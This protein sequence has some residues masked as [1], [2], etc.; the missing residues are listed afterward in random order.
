VPSRKSSKVNRPLISDRGVDII[1]VGASAGGLEA[2]Q[3]LLSNLPTIENCCVI[4]AQ[5]LSPTHKSMLVQ[6]LSK[7][8]KILV[9]E[10]VN[11]SQ[12][13]AGN[14]YI[15]PP[16]KEISVINGVIKL[17]KPSAPLGP[18]PSVDVL[19]SSLANETD[20]RV[21]GVIL[22]GTG[23]DGSHGVQALKKVGHYIIAQEPETAK[24][25]GMPLAA[26]ETGV[27][28]AVLSPE[29]IGEEIQDFFNDTVRA[30]LSDDTSDKSALSKILMLLGKRT[31]TDFSK[32]K[33]ATIGRRLLK[34]MSMLKIDSLDDYLGYLEHHPHEVDEMFNMILIG[35]T[36]F[37]RDFESFAALEDQ[38][39]KI[40]STKSAKDS[41]RIWVPGCSTG[42]EAYSVAIMLHRILED[43]FN[44]FNIQIF[45]TDIDE[46]AIKKGRLGI[47]PKTSID[48]VPPEIL[49]RYFMNLGDNYEL[50][51]PI[52]SVVLFSKHDVTKNPPFLNLDLISCRNLLIYFESSLQEQIIPIFHYALVPDGLL[53]LGKSESVG[54]FGD[55][56][57]NI[58]SK[59]KLFRRKL[60]KSTRTLKFSAFKAAHKTTAV[61][62]RQLQQKTTTLFDVL[63]DT[64]F[65]TYEHP[66]V[67]VD[68]NGDIKEVNG[69]VRLFMSLSTGTIHMNLIRMLNPELQIEVRSILSKAIKDKTSI[70]SGVK[71]FE[72]FG[73]QYFVRINVKSLQS[74]L[75]LDDLYLVIF[76]NLDISEFLL[77]GNTENPEEASSERLVE[78]EQELAATKEQLQTY[79][80]EI[81]TSNEEL[82]SLNEELQSTNEELQS[83]NEE[84]ETSNEELQ[85][86]NEEVQIAYTGLKAALDE[87]ELKEHLLRDTAASTESLLDND[88]QAFVLL[89][90]SYNVVRY[91]AKAD[92]TFHQL[93]NKKITTSKS[94]VDY[95]PSGNAE[96]FLNG[97]RNAL[98]G[99][100]LRLE[101]ELSDA[102]GNMR[103]YAMNFAPAKVSKG[104]VTGVSIGILDITDLRLALMQLNAKE[105][106]VR[107]VFDTV[108]TGICIVDELGNFVDMNDEFCRI[109]GYSKDELYN[110]TIAESPLHLV[111]H[112]GAF[113]HTDGHHE[114]KIPLDEHEIVR[115][116]GSKIVVSIA[117]NELEPLEGKKFTVL[118]VSDITLR[119]QHQESLKML[120]Q[121]LDHQA[122]SLA[123]INAEL[124]QFAYSASH[125]LQEPLRMIISFLTLLEKKYT[126]S[127]DAK[128]NEYIHYAVDGARRMRKIILDL[129]DYSRAGKSTDNVT[130]VDLNEVV[131]DVLRL[132]KQTIQE[133]KAKFDV[134]GLPILQTHLAPM[135]QLLS[136]LI[137]NSLKYSSDERSPHI[138]IGANLL[139]RHWEIYVKDNGIGISH[140]YFE[141]IFMVFQ[142][143]HSSE[144]YQGIGMGLAIVK[145]IVDSLGGTVRVESEVDLGS[146]FYFTLP[147]S[148][149]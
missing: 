70:R 117:H 110:G 27:V 24:Y 76:E 5:H 139:D 9:T 95:L 85:S 118:S 87:L 71:R 133:K 38:L 37:F 126:N 56:F 119:H 98:V 143:L 84:L 115:Q 10:A 86:T 2:L 120:N 148:A 44:D 60:T 6:L 1:A 112:D 104:P 19:F 128:A 99:V 15:T 94:I 54:Q 141:K 101:K 145:K 81:E 121:Q 91:N 96:D 111:L 21:I 3:S 34:R 140:E 14:I 73:S 89:D 36:T 45:A 32:Y 33:K 130:E 109:C 132:H 105:L 17:K 18:K 25:D 26:I 51:K 23:S 66:Y 88:L 78:L 93:S 11:G 129:L 79:I 64:I 35:V 67:V 22:S 136:N 8:T 124:E 106:L 52:R 31:G 144:R 82:Q 47:Y 41:V 40:L 138:T 80:E 127:L 13:Q 135:N 97:I 72:L 123:E 131:K 58:D 7:E 74:T 90:T 50:I 75:L 43:R 137:G 4:V 61:S 59:N 16:D 77:K 100:S 122:I 42:E 53:L 20:R 49:E 62:N 63:K 68:S 92:T 48:T 147:I 125:D 39:Q 55:L 69:D 116:D 114:G 149:T 57:S 12:L 102:E 28:D 134:I 108:S 113:S 29:K 146:T 30:R 83:S 65:S 103:W 46:R 142:R 107:A